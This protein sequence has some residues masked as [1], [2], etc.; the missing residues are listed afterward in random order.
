MST[1]S[2]SS[3]LE[4][5]LVCGRLKTTKRQGWINNSV[6]LPESIGDHMHRMGVMAFAML[7]ASSSVSAKDLSAN[8]DGEDGTAKR[9][10]CIKM[11]IVHDLAEA[12]VG[13]ITPHDNVSKEEKRRLEEEAMRDMVADIGEP[14]KE[15]LELWLQY[16]EGKSSEAIFVK[17]LDKLEMIIQAFEYER[18][19]KKDLSEFFSST[20]GKFKH[21]KTLEIVDALLAKRKD[22]LK[23][24]QWRKPRNQSKA[25][26]CLSEHTHFFPSPTNH[27]SCMASNASNIRARPAASASNAEAQAFLRDEERDEN[28]RFPPGE[29]DDFLQKAGRVTLAELKRPFIFFTLLLSVLLL[30]AFIDRLLIARNIDVPEP[31]SVVGGLSVAVF[32]EGWA[33]CSRIKELKKQ[34]SEAYL[35]GESKLSIKPVVNMVNML[36]E[37]SFPL[38]G[39]PS[40]PRRNQRYFALQNNTDA[41]TNGNPIL[42]KDAVVLDGVGGKLVAVDVALAHGLVVKIGKNLS[43]EDVVQAASHHASAWKTQASKRGSAEAHEEWPEFAES[44]VLIINV[45][46]RYV[47]PGLVDMHSHVG[48][49]SFPEL[50]ATADVNENGLGSTNPQ[51]RVV[52]SFNVLDEG[53]DVIALGGVTTSLVLPGSGS[54]IGGEGYPIK[55]LRT[56]SNEVEDF[57]IYHEFD[58]ST[59]GKRWRYIKMACGENPKG[60]KDQPS[61]RMGSGWLFRK[62]FE[63]AWNTVNAQDDWCEAAQ[64][65]VTRFGTNARKFITSRFP[66]PKEDD[67][68]VALLRGDVRLQVHCYET[69]DIE[70]MVRTKHEFGFKIAA[71]HHALEAHLVAPLLA[72]ENISAAIFADQGLYKKEAYGVSVKA[73]KILHDAGVKVAY[74]S[75]HPV[76]NAQHLIYEA[77]KAA[78]YGLDPDAAFAAVTSVPAERLGLGWRVGRLAV[79][80]DADVL[81]WDR[82]PLD[83][84]AHPLK[85]IIDGFLLRKA[86]RDLGRKVQPLPPATP[87]LEEKSAVEGGSVG[88]RRPG[89]NT[90]TYTVTN[91]TKIFVDDGDVRKGSVV[92]EKGV[93]TCVGHRCT[94]K[95]DVYD[96]AGGV[97]IPGIVGANLNLG[98]VEIP[99]E[100]TMNNGKSSSASAVEGKV[101]AV[102]GLRVGGGSKKLTAAYRGGVLTAISV[103]DTDG[104][105]KGLSVALRTGAEHYDEAIL[106]ATVAYH[107]VVGD[108]GKKDSTPSIA[109]QITFLRDLL[110]NTTAG[111]PAHQIAT[112]KVP[113]VVEAE[114]PNDIA[115]VLGLKRTLVPDLKLVVAGASGAWDVAASLAE[116]SVPVLLTPARCV[117]ITWETRWCKVPST[118]PSAAALLAAA[119][120]K[121]L[122]SQSGSALERNLLWEAGWALQDALAAEGE[123]RTPGFGENEAIG[124]ITWNVAKAFGIDNVAGTVLVGRRASFLGIN[125]ADSP[126]GFGRSIQII[127][128]GGDVTVRPEQD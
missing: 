107:A 49:D 83:L 3:L 4:F 92:V 96:L 111:T 25:R 77:Q 21:P 127:A 73:G 14:G 33:Q 65:A 5:L 16:E 43:K 18:D 35:T 10:R 29:E 61:S 15:M 39:P 110:T 30:A 19:Q 124:A 13:D 66:A 81:V 11:A 84:G 122:L 76:L 45:N 55:L 95:G 117:P 41:A 69:H 82:H 17:D 53:I 71:F 6:H 103:P 74:K 24:E 78:Q 28:D 97:I 99:R 67:S 98:L 64:A 2:G 68:I 120:V 20:I 121:V 123:V 94:S 102:D 72:R 38:G 75:D 109:S 87:F 125:S 23:L 58:E 101:R 7:D 126:F 93:V 46:G 48:A 57:S 37:C 79:G 52:D 42:I 56:V 27:A 47:T 44:D 50:D 86:N 60:S 112:G 114:D 115:K 88:G 62:R 116:L 40:P 100:S 1:G 106:K 26:N 91:A 31:P 119:G 54:L 8:G 80:Y 36:M 90:S 34:N 12:I 118:H 59:D 105:F 89:A 104:M 51:L 22:T 128:D 63:K 9:R 108:S 70:M 85:V 32:E 113:L